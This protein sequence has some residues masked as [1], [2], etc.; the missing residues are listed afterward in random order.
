MAASGLGTF[1]LCCLFA[2]SEAL[3]ERIS[4]RRNLPGEGGVAVSSRSRVGEGRAA[5]LATIFIS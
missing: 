3:A 2:S 5:L 1:S 4:K